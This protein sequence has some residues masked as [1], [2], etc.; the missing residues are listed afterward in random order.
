MD[1]FIPVVP[2]EKFH[3]A[4][5]QLL[6]P[7]LAPERDL[8]NTWA[9]GFVDRDGKFVAEFQKSFEPCLWEIYLFAVFKQLSIQVSFDNPAPDFEITG[10]NPCCIEAAVAKPGR[11]D[12][13]A[14][15]FCS[16]ILP[17]VPSD[18]DKF[19]ADS[20]VR[21]C[22]SF[23]VKEKKYTESYSKLPHVGTLPFIIAIASYDRPHS[24]FAGDRPILAALY[25]IYYD[26]KS[27]QLIEIDAAVKENGAK[28]PV[29]HFRSTSYSHISAVIFS[30]VATW[31]KVRA[32]A[33]NPS[34]PAYFNT[35]HGDHKSGIVTE[36]REMSDTYKEDLVDGLIV[37]HNA[38]ADRPLVPSAFRHSRIAQWYENE[39]GMLVYEGPDDF[40]LTRKLLSYLPNDI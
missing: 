38:Y 7:V 13:E 24:T 19:N 4:F 35:F 32:L 28:V 3:P 8:L 26:E 27:S 22:N 14:S 16:S 11:D 29:R 34:S 33:N 21:I 10:E 17:D 25:G 9:A 30:S 18:F 37:C 39:Q 2:E 40:L 23:S 31:G 5:A 12:D 15:G 1:L 6:H 36:R 20:T